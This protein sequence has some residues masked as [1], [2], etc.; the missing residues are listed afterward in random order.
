MGV[1]VSGGDLCRRQ[2]HRPRRQPR[3]RHY[4]Y[5][6]QNQP[7]TINV[8]RMNGT[9][10]SYLKQVNQDAEETLFQTVKQMAKSE[11]V[12]EALKA[13]DQ[14]EWG[15]GVQWTP[16]PQGEAPTE[17]TAETRRM[18]NI[19]NRAEEIVILSINKTL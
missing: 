16:L 19:R 13:S 3:Q 1:R 9:L 14:L 10:E 7:T 8:M 15:A 5:I 11:G 4:E 2:K 17:A 6:K 18:N 12:T